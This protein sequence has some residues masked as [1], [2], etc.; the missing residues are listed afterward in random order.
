MPLFEHVQLGE[1]FDLAIMSTKGMATTAAR[2]LVE[3]LCGDSGVPLLVLDDF[4]KAGLSIAATLGRDTRRYQFEDEINIIDIGLRLDDVRAL[5]LEGAAESTF[6]RGS[7]IARR[8]N[9]KANGATDDEVRFLL[10]RR[11]ELNALPSD[12]LVAFIERKLT[13]HGVAKVVPDDDML[14]ETYRAFK[15]GQRLREI[16][17]REIANA[18]EGDLAV[19]TGLREEVAARL[20]KHPAW[21]WDDAVGKIARLTREA[22]PQVPE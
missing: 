7:S 4:D 20:K 3:T 13:E 21:R 12:E 14:A 8:E 15:R 11:V 18:A 2:R 19:P 6:D 1:R 10:E 16:F 5:G 22:K 9:L 17:K